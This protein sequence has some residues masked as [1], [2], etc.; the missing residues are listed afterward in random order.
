M[1]CCDPD[2]DRGYKWALVYSI[3][4]H[5]ASLD[6]LM[7]RVQSLSA[8]VILLEATTGTR[9]MQACVL[10]A[11]AVFLPLTCARF[12][13]LPQGN[14]LVALR[15]QS[16]L[17]VGA[18]PGHPRALCLVCKAVVCNGRL[19]G[20]RLALAAAAA[21]AVALCTYS[22]GPAAPK[23]RQL[24]ELPPIDTSSMQTPMGLAWEVVSTLPFTW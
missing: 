21:A 6:S 23:P 13:W 24:N 3:A 9:L 4:K 11:R 14:A 12:V 22:P 7:S 16:G 8:T 10:H 18:M 20:L 19:P 2:H 1:V 5:G 15:P 17:R